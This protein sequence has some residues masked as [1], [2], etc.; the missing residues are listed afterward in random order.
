MSGSGGDFYDEQFA[1]PQ[2]AIESK[3]SSIVLR[4][5][6]KLNDFREQFVGQ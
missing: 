6:V 1:V 3:S 4:S 2:P 5:A